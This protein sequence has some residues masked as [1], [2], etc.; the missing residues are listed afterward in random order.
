[1]KSDCKALAAATTELF[2]A[3]FHIHPTTVAYAPGRV[4]L[5]GEHVDYSG[6]FVLP[7]A[8]CRGTAAAGVLTRDGLLTAVSSAFAGETIEVPMAQIRPGGATGWSSYVAGVV[9]QYRDTLPPGAGVR[10]LLNSTVPLGSG[11]S[12]SAALEVSTAMLVRGLC[13]DVG[14]AD[15]GVAVACRRAEHE[16]AGVPCGIMDQY[17][18]C[19]GRKGHALLIDCHSERHELVSI[20]PGVSFVVADCGVR[21]AL[22][23]SEYPMRRAACERALAKIVNALG[24]RPSLRRCRVEDIEA[25]GLDGMDAACARHAVEESARTRAFAAAARNED[26]ERCGALMAASHAS[27]RD[28]YRVSCPELDA[29]VEFAARQAG[30]FGA[31]MTGGGFGGCIVAMCKDEAASDITARLMAEGGSPKAFST[32]PCAGAWAVRADI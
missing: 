24:P 13:G 32:G 29:L 17:I 3:K 28:L 14:A 25:S 23:S 15:S 7:I 12:S 1:M 5:I 30:V 6:G 19:M 2:K 20:P 8:I 10:M 16:Y 26:L 4:N 22:G 18:S 11:L 9:A 31:R 21:H 27:L